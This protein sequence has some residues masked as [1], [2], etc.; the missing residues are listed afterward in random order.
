MVQADARVVGPAYHKMGGEAPAAVH[1]HGCG[2]S[3]VCH[4]VICVSPRMEFRGS[5][6]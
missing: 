5:G 4:G 3:R 1:F 6:G 2:T